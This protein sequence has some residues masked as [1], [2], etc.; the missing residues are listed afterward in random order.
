M[1]LAFCHFD[2]PL[3]GMCAVGGPHGLTCVGFVEVSRLDAFLN[4]EASRVG[5]TITTRPNATPER[6]KKE[7]H[8]YFA[9]SRKKFGVPID[10]RGTDFQKTV[11]RALLDIPFGETRSY[12]Q[13]A[14]ALGDE[15]AT[16]AVGTANGDN[17]IAIIVPCHR[18]VE[19]GGALGGYAGGLWRKERLLALERGQSSLKM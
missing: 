7:L 11:W 19:S 12:L 16:R 8:E 14:R 5:A 1:E 4:A 10:L 9:G 2:T 6:A 3:G 15:K 17:P 13:I 18:V